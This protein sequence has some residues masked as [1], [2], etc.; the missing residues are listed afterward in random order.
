MIPQTPRQRRAAVEA[1]YAQQ[2]ERYVAAWV[3]ERAYRISDHQ[4]A[5]LFLRRD[6]AGRLHVETDL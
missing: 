4:A 2:M 6:E 3:A 5:A 1:Y